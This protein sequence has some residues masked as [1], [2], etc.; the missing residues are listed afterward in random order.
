MKLELVYLIFFW[1]LID[2]Q[3]I[4]KLKIIERSHHNETAAALCSLTF[5][6]P[7]IFPSG[8]WFWTGDLPLSSLASWLP[9]LNQIRLPRGGSFL[10]FSWPFTLCKNIFR[11]QGLVQSRAHVLTRFQWWVD[12]WIWWR[13]ALM[14]PWCSA[15]QLAWYEIQNMWSSR[16]N[17]PKEQTDL[18]S[19][20]CWWPV[21]VTSV[22]LVPFPFLYSFLCLSSHICWQK[23]SVKY[24]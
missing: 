3:L 14:F 13:L 24:N 22:C 11:Q 12:I 7:D 4:I 6:V 16:C 23:K 5:T 18:G 2:Q 21:S 8:R 17:S 1:H 10:A 20:H 15:E 9:L 19:Q